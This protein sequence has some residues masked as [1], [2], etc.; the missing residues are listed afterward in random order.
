MMKA[1]FMSLFV[2]AVV[3]AWAGDGHA[4]PMCQ[5]VTTYYEWVCNESEAAWE[6]MPVDQDV[7]YCS[8]AHVPAQYTTDCMS[9][10]QVSCNPYNEC[11]DTDF[12]C[13]PAPAAPCQCSGT[14]CGGDCVDLM[15]DDAH[16]G[17]CGSACGA[18]QA[19]VEG[20]CV[21]VAGYCGCGDSGLG[22]VCTVA[23]DGCSTG[24][25]PYCEPAQGP[26]C[27]ACSCQ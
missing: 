25:H 16:C 20:E 1:T 11:D 17:A 9:F 23:Y 26:G 24:Y 19:C 4:A 10:Y 22:N 7:L 8:G 2:A 12:E 18:G 3:S 27:G 14:M 5:N 6:L 15:N 21:H 13:P